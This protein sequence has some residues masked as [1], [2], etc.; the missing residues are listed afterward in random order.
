VI[1]KLSLITPQEVVQL[2]KQKHRKVNCPR[3]HSKWFAK[4]GQEPKQSWLQ[5]PQFALWNTSSQICN[6]LHLHV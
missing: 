3:S 6:C 2:D 4:P 1:D 5:F